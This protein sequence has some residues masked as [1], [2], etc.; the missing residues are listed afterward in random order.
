MAQLTDDDRRRALEAIA[1]HH[2]DA[3]V[4]TL[5]IGDAYAEDDGPRRVLHLEPRRTCLAG[6]PY[7]TWVVTLV[8]GDVVAVE[9][10]VS[11]AC[12]TR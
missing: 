9:R 6:E 5:G 1:H 2:P 10:L 7:T 12:R 4:L 3:E 8:A 11:R